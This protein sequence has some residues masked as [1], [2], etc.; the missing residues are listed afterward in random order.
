MYIVLPAGSQQ[1]I[2]N[3]ATSFDAPSLSAAITGLDSEYVGVF[4]PKWQLS[5]SIADF[6]PNLAALGMGIAATD[7]ADFSGMFKTPS[8][9]SRAIH[10]TFI[11]VSEQGTEAAAAT[12]V[13]VVT[14]IAPNR[15]LIQVN[16]PFLYFIVEKQSGTVLFMGT[17]NDPTAA[18]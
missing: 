18:N 11:D 6:L 17:I 15:P 2:E 14:S 10:K 12:A 9:V 7:S 16:H 8:H 1:P 13:G 5:Y 4:L 3:F